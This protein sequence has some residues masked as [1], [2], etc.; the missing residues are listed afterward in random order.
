MEKQQRTFNGLMATWLVAWGLI[1]L[2]PE[3]NGLE[4]T[5]AVIAIAA[6]ILVFLDR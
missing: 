5:L 2:I 4:L 3:L 6:G 1:T